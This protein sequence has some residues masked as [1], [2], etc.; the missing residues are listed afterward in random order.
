MYPLYQADQSHA[1][2]AEALSACNG[3]APGNDPAV[4]SCFERDR[5]IHTHRDATL[6]FEA[7]Y[8][9]TRDWP[10]SIFLVCILPPALVYVLIRF[11][12][13]G[14]LRLFSLPKRLSK[15]RLLHRASS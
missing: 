4:Q 9:E 15:A 1:S 8:G 10:V 5:S 12:L 13:F 11:A 7:T 6:A 3:A 14:M 2:E